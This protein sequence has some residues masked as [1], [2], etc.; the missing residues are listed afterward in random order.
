MNIYTDSRLISLNTKNATKLN[1]S[2][3][4]NLVFNLRGL[5]KEEAD[6][7]MTTIEVANYQIPI[8]FYSINQ[9]NN[10]LN[11]NFTSNKS[12]TIAQ[13]NYSA[14]TFITQLQNQILANGDSITITINRNTGI[15]TFTG[16]A[17][18]TFLSTSTVLSALG[19]PPTSNV[20]SVSNVLVASYPLNLSGVNRI[21]LTSQNL[22]TIS[23]SSNSVSNILAN[24]SINRPPF[25]I[26]TLDNAYRITKVLKNK[27]VDT[28]DFAL[29]DENGNL[30]NFNGLDWTI[31]ISLNIIR[32]YFLP[33]PLQMPE[34]LQ[35]QNSTIP[36]LL[37]QSKKK[38]DITPQ[39]ENVLDDPELN[40][41]TS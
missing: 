41:L 3:N 37:A 24:I 20:S 7:V 32:K 15:L 2:F 36:S 30:V 6:I 35:N 38:Q 17:N 9:Y 10:V 31:S 27:I 14:F 5:L 39:D 13:G 1:G 40:I 22:A 29:Y 16:T 34:I 4:S 12:I 19:F 18:F 11:Y 25:S 28:I 21:S 33:N 8:S 23:Y 26:L